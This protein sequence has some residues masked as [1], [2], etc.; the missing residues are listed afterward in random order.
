MPAPLVDEGTK[1][2]TTAAPHSA[3]SAST[4][5]GDTMATGNSTDNYVQVNQAIKQNEKIRA[6]GCGGGGAYLNI[7]RVSPDDSANDNLQTTK[8]IINMQGSQLNS[9]CG[10]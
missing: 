10:Y 9:T 1:A 2:L 3:I 8:L 7:R 4:N 5:D 6:V